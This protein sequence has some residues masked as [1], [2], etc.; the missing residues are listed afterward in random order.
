MTDLTSTPDASVG[1]LDPPQPPGASPTGAAAPPPPWPAPPRRNWIARFVRGK[2]SDAAWVRPALLALLV[3]TSVLYIWGL[4]ASG[5]ANSFYS[6]AVQAGTKSWKA[7]FFG[8]S[9]SS[10]FI[11][12]DK[13]PVFLWPME[14]S[15]RIF[16]L[17]SWSMLIPQALE[18]VATVGLVYLSVRRWFSA[19]AALLGGAVVALTPVAAMMFRFNNPDALL[20]LLLTA[21]TYA[22]MRGIEKAQTKWLVLAGALIGFGF[23]TKMM[24]AFLIIPVMAV[25]YLLAAPTGWWRR[26]WQTFLMGVSVLVAAGWWVAIVAL[27]PAADRPYVGGSQ[28][29]SIL[30]LI[31]GYNGFGRLDGSE[32][33]SVGGGRV[34]GSMWGP[35]GITRLFNAEFGNMMSWL[36][37]GALVMG[38]VLLVVT[39]RARRTDRE[40]AGLLL[41]GGS[42]VSIGLVIS[43]AQGIIH[44]YY[45]VALAPPLG[46]LV[47][48]G[49]MGLW[50]RR[51]TWVG[52]IGLAAGLAATV[53]WSYILLGRTSDWF[54]ALRPFVAVAGALGVVAILALPLLR[55][56]PK[57]AIIA[58]ATLGFGAALAA[59]LFSTIATAATPHSGAIPSVTPTASGGFGGPGG[60]FGG[61][62]AGGFPGGARRAFGG[63]TQG[64]FPGAGG[65]G[66]GGFPGAG[67]GFR[68]GAGTGTGAGAGAGGFAGGAPSFGGGGGGF[69]RRVGAGGAAGG[70]GFLNSSTSNAALNK[71]LQADASKYTW[72]AATVN[73]NNAAGYQLGSGEPIM[74]IGGFNGTDPAPTLAQFEKDVAEG[75]IHYYIAS[76][77]GGFGGGGAGSDDASQITSWVESHFTAQTIG[78]V[79]VYNLTTGTSS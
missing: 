62:G 74:A 47:G 71:A 1:V 66:A 29:N 67:Q 64:G 42:L 23:I 39:I 44:P 45:T 37:P 48:I 76:G 50:Q 68:R 59:P 12:V 52:R 73:S 11:T 41:W 61:A 24:Q 31:F 13:P 6:A 65:A 18:G 46:A 27:T 43:L 75:K 49:T 22:T 60:G 2:E 69:G 77:G 32:S 20:A 30:N 70:A 25:V 72:A 9:D 8:S 38:A 26:V 34:G 56:V 3:A 55:K 28:N 63:G 57:L 14:I 5:W 21:A 36:L 53:V 15:A 58:V 33:G 7:M 4:G 78:G 16:G 10:N 35:T 51:A 79:T 19:Q 17:N 40:R 54:P